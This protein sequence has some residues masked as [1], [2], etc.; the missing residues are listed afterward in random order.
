[1]GELDAA[2]ISRTLIYIVAG[3]YG[4]SRSKLHRRMF[5]IGTAVLC[6]SFAYRLVGT[7]GLGMGDLR[8]TSNAGAGIMMATILYDI[9]GDYR[10][11]K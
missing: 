8:W 11:G 1:M 10:R 3:F 7:L 2:T 6:W 4:L 5:G 9:Y